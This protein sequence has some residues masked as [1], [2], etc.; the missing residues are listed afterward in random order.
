MCKLF[1]LKVLVYGKKYNVYPKKNGIRAK[2][3]TIS[4]GIESV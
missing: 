2:K 1:M 3:C 4:R